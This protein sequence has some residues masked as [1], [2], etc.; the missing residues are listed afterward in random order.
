MILAKP[1]DDWK[2]RR[3]LRTIQRLTCAMAIVGFLHSL[4][5]ALWRLSSAAL[6]SGDERAAILNCAV[7]CFFCVAAVNVW[8]V[9]LIAFPA[10]KIL[11]RVPKV[12]Q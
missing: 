6:L 1:S 7:G 5:I 11:T 4:D 2:E 3:Q 12:N 9:G 10:V 8:F